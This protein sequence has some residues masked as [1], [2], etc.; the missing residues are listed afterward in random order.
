MH[1]VIE[2][3]IKKVTHPV[4]SDRGVLPADPDKRDIEEI[5]RVVTKAQDLNG[6]INKATNILELELEEQR[7]G[8]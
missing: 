4:K 8:K 3:N 6:A 7:D 1:Y 5:T 2:V